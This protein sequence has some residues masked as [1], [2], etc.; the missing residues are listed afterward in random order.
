[1][2]KSELEWCGWWGE[3]SGATELN[4]LSA[5]SWRIVP[6]DLQI[7]LRMG[8]APC[9]LCQVCQVCLRTYCTLPDQ[10]THLQG[11]GGVSYGAL[12]ARMMHQSQGGRMMLEGDC[13]YV[14]VPTIGTFSFCDSPHQPR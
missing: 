6:F 4:A 5:L 13:S 12:S 8:W 7:A 1:M 10:I 9:L 2:V 11:M 3:H 14:A